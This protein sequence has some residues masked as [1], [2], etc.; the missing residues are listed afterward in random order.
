LKVLGLLQFCTTV[1]AEFYG[2]HMFSSGVRYV[3]VN[4]GKV[5]PVLN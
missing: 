3:Y 5:V 1:R 4:K 2:L